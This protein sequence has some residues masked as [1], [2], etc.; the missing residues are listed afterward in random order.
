M[1]GI[2]EEQVDTGPA[3]VWAVLRDQ[4]PGWAGQPLTPVGR[5]GTDH[6]VYRI[7]TDHVARFPRTA[8][9]A[10]SLDLEVVVLPRVAGLVP[11]QVPRVEH[12]GFPGPLYPHRWAVLTWIEGEDAWARRRR[13]EDPHGE[14]LAHDLA[15]LVLALRAAP[16]LG[17]VPR[18]AP[19][20]RGGPVAGVLERAEAWLSGS[21]GALP[22]WVDARLVRE[23]LDAAREAADDE[24][25]YVLSHGDLVPGNVLLRRRRLGAVID[26]G[27]LG[28]ADPALDLVPAWAMLGPRAR[29][30]FREHLSPDDA[31]WH[32]ARANAVEQALGGLVHH[33][34]AHHPLGDVMGRTLRRVLDEAGPDGA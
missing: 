13:V 31:T 30:A 18:R 4:W 8:R 28:L 10:A 3:T 1:S 7:G 6:A 33:G 17:V 5:T 23:V 16:P 12:V 32:R 14:A 15:D 22:P 20:R 29:A 9:A 26:W 24:V 27:Y 25:R 2:P 11:V 19:G 21:R 34:P